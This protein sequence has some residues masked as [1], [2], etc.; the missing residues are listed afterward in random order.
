MSNT[1][2]TEVDPPN[3]LLVNLTEYFIE[4]IS[5]AEAIRRVNSRPIDPIIKEFIIKNLPDNTPHYIVFRNGLLLEFATLRD[6]E[7]FLML[8]LPYTTPPGT[9]NAY[10][11]KVPLAGCS[12]KSTFST[13]DGQL[14]ENGTLRPSFQFST[15]RVQLQV[16]T[17][18]LLWNGA[19]DPQPIALPCE[20]APDPIMCLCKLACEY[21]HSTLDIHWADGICCFYL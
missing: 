12:D 17:N 11:V 13:S 6:N 19:N 4:N 16:N 15:E 20:Y 3:I 14:Y 2:I 8:K 1:N 9:T 7:T 18:A 10:E 21:V 5:K